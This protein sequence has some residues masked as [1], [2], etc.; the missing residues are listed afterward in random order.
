VTSRP[1]D[2]NATFIWATRGRTWGF[3]FL[4]H[5]GVE[6][7]LGVYEDA[8]SLVDDQP[9]AW[10]RVDDKVALRFPDPDGRR[11]AAGRVIPHDF[12]LL[13]RWAEEIESLED[14]RRRVWHEV[15]DEFARVWDKAEPPSTQE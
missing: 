13:G 7:P 6:D 14:G 12:V 4:R 8:F 2:Q 3:R 11:D 1:T 5:G 9:E 15:A 10:R